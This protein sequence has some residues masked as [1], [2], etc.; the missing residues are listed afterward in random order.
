MGVRRLVLSARL[1]AIAGYIPQGD[2]LADIGTDHAYLPIAVA[3]RGL[4]TKVIATDLHKNPYQSA[5]QAVLDSGLDDKIEVRLGDGLKP[6]QP[7][8]AQTVVLAGMGG[9][10]IVNILANA[11][12]VLASVSRLIMQP[13]ADASTLRLWLVSHGWR[14][15]EEQ[16]IKENERIYEILVAVPGIEQE[17]DLLRI[18]LG[19]RLLEN[20]DLLLKDYLD[21][22]KEEYQKILRGLA[23]SQQTAIKSKQQMIEKKLDAI[24]KWLNCLS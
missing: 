3:E 20:K 13:M 7:G 17:K 11:S 14:L 2:V 6:L 1:A 12:N 8:E 18:E 23:R 21:K 16:L 19:P 22:Q 9:G 10:T 4:C 24:R 15:Y 5:C